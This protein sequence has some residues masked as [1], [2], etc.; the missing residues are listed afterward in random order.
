MTGRSR[1][2]RSEHAEQQRNNE[3]HEK[4]VE[5]NLR[6]LGSACCNPGKA[7]H[8]RDNRNDEKNNGVMEHDDL[9]SWWVLIG[10]GSGNESGFQD[11]SGGRLPGFDKAGRNV[12]GLSNDG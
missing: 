2:S 9:P 11:D 1:R 10:L 3:N 12:R 6:D 5:Q 4:D 7:E 8:S